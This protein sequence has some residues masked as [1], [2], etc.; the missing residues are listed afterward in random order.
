MTTLYGHQTTQAMSTII[1]VYGDKRAANQTSRA[2]VA[3]GG[4]TEA[5]WWGGGRGLAVGQGVGGKRGS[6]GSTP[7]ET[8]QDLRLQPSRYP[9]NHML[10]GANSD[11]GGTG[12]ESKR[13][14]K[15]SDGNGDS[16]EDPGV[17]LEGDGMGFDRRRRRHDEERDNG[18]NAGAVFVAAGNL[19]NLSRKV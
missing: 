8:R 14:P 18:G 19:E 7:E 15:L 16:N 11:G 9:D 13:P 3:G 17:S 1:R 10:S 6:A 12:I 5:R 4:R 2:G